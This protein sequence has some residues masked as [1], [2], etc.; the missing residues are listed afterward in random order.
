MG[1]GKRGRAATRSHECRKQESSDH[2]PT[3]PDWPGR[4]C[5]PSSPD[6]C[7]DPVRTSCAL[8]PLALPTHVTPLVAL[9]NSAPACQTRD[10]T[11]HRPATLWLEAAPVLHRSPLCA[12]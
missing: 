3:S 11:A 1:V 9:C 4:P 2:G 8:S 6:P 10:C 7:G 5:I 12:L